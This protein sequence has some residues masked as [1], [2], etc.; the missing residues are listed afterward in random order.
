M[1]KTAS[2]YLIFLLSFCVFVTKPAFPTPMT[3][4][5]N[6]PFSEAGINNMEGQATA[7]PLFWAVEDSALRATDNHFTVDSRYPGRY[8]NG[9]QFVRDK[10]CEAS[11]FS[12]VA[13]YSPDGAGAPGSTWVGSGYPA[14]I[15]AYVSTGNLSD[16]CQFSP[17]DDSHSGHPVG[18]G[19]T[20]KDY[21]YLISASDNYDWMFTVLTLYGCDVANGSLR[22]TC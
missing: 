12:G 22:K 18:M 9:P 5:S 11:N 21:D 4:L 13:I 17:T 16:S 2:A 10:M 8:L 20:S 6:A 15:G 14:E 1:R 7:L 19:F 3:G